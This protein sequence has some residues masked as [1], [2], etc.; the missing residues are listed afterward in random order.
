ML[1]VIMRRAQAKVSVGT[2]GFWHLFAIAK[3]ARECR[4]AQKT[5]FETRERT[6]LIEAKRLEKELD[7]LIELPR[8]TY[9]GTP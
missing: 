9:G 2:D 8:G 6:H 1:D 5:Y 7:D 3:V 4:D